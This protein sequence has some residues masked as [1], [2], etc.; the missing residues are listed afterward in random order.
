MGIK[1]LIRSNSPSLLGIRKIGQPNSGQLS[2]LRYK[3]LLKCQAGVRATAEN[4][5]G[6]G[7]FVRPWARLAVA[8]GLIATMKKGNF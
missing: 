5:E 7:H 2:W 8:Q 1:F 3:A 4:R 6:S